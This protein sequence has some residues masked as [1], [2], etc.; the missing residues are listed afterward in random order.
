MKFEGVNEPYFKYYIGLVQDE[1]LIDALENACNSQIVFFKSIDD[2]K[3]NYRYAENKW[4]VKEVLQHLIDTERIFVYRALT[5]LR[6]ANA[7]LPGY[8]HDA[9]VSSL[10]LALVPY[11]ELVREYTDLKRSNLSF[12]KNIDSNDLERSGTA[13]GVIMS[14]NDIGK[15]MVGHAHHHIEI[16]KDRYLK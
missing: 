16:L 9:Y 1:N 8:D 5:F 11:G 10:K 7:Q 3:G 13:N 12:F 6:Q 14:V 4:S 15:I 2:K